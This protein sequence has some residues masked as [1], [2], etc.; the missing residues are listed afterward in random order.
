VFA[1]LAAVDGMVVTAERGQIIVEDGPVDGPKLLGICQQIIADDKRAPPGLLRW[2]RLRARSEVRG[3]DLTDILRD[4]GVPR[5]TF[6]PRT[7]AVALRVVAVLN[8]LPG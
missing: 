5:S 4:L 6:Y 1:T 8:A 2:L 3:D 7:T